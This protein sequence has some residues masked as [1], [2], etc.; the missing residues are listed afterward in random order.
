LGSKHV[1]RSGNPEGSRVI[2]EKALPPEAAILRGQTT[3]M[4]LAPFQ[5]RF[6]YRLF[7]VVLDIDHIAQATRALRLFSYNRG[8]LF[9]FHDRDHGDRSG[10]PLRPWAE[11]AFASAGVALAGG[12]IR[13][14]AFPRLFGHVFNPISLFLGYR[15]DGRLA[16]VIYEVNNTF[17]HSHSY[18]APIDTA[19]RAAHEAA[20]LLH[21]SPFFDVIGDYRFQLRT[22]AETL[23]LVIENWVEGARTHLA[24][25]RG[26]TAALTDA[27]L[28][29]YALAAPWR[30]GLVLG[31]IH[32]QALW[33]W[34]RGAGYR[35]VPAPPAEKFSM[36]ADRL[37][38]AGENT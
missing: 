14:V 8:N 5:R 22:S 24:T 15:P 31:A 9:S 13:I 27:A 34:L 25:L 26:K 7:Q 36:A 35:P 10:A 30:A 1:R 2:E 11:A 12:P 29:G 32:W 18:V 21:V 20:K 33:I 37:S 17:G 38:H 3:H 19:G 4:R 23:S 28:A 6:S 16:G